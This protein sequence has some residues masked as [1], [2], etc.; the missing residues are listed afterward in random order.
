MSEMPSFYAKLREGQKAVLDFIKNHPLVSLITAQLPGG[1]GKTIAAYAAYIAKREAKSVDRLLMVVAN[2]TQVN[3]ILRECRQD[4]NDFGIKVRTDSQG[5]PVYHYRNDGQSVLYARNGTFE[6]FVTTIQS[7]DAGVKNGTVFSLLRTGNW[8]LFLDETHHLADDFSWGETVKLLFGEIK[9]VLAVSATPLRE[10]LRNVF[11]KQGTD[12][13]LNF[14]RA[15]DEGNVLKDIKIRA[16]DFNIK[17]FQFEGDITY[18]ASDLGTGKVLGNAREAT[19]QT[20]L[21]RFWDFINPLLNKAFQR[22]IER[23]AQMRI[24]GKI[25]VRVSRQW[26]A[27]EVAKMVSGRF[28]L[29]AD[30]IG[31]D[32][33]DEATNQAV[34]E[35]FLM[36]DGDDKLDV[37]IQ[38]GM[39]GEGFNCK[40]IITLVDLTAPRSVFGIQTKQFILRGVRWMPGIAAAHQICDIYVPAD[41]FLAG[42][43]DPIAWLDGKIEIVDEEPPKRKP[44]GEDEDEGEG[45]D[46]DPYGPYAAEL[47]EIEQDE[48]TRVAFAHWKQSGDIPDDFMALIKETLYNIKK[49]EREQFNRR[50]QDENAKSLTASFVNKCVAR[51]RKETG[52]EAVGQ[53]FD[54]HVRKAHSALNNIIRKLFKEEEHIKAKFKRAQED[55]KNYRHRNMRP[56][57]IQW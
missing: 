53:G 3:Q 15:L 43:D 9:F 5:I 39:A 8:L 41:H 56:V 11:G 37:L 20:K 24:R 51:R 52:L 17:S 50:A 40:R 31:C 42:V 16:L 28:G 38:V 21:R 23:S 7:V 1:Y 29:S 14:Q 48:I 35:R 27:E 34:I 4:L 36:E 33:R 49:Q 57:W 12:V 32:L 6:I 26:I 10:D 18:K 46:I 55:W 45:D 25:L 30:W 54:E 44:K 2:L 47:I 22:T 19:E 13:C